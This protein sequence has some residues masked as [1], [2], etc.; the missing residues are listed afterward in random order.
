MFLLRRSLRHRGL[1]HG[2]VPQNIS[3]LSA[4]KRQL[5]QDR[6]LTLQ[7]TAIFGKKILCVRQHLF[8]HRRCNGDGEKR[9]QVHQ[10][11]VLLGLGIN[12]RLRVGG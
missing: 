11:M 9:G 5:C 4:A 1:Q 2:F 10:R 7:K 3:G 6:E 12:T 8:E